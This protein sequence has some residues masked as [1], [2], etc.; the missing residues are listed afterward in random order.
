M[1][2]RVAIYCRLSEE[3]REKDGPD[4]QSIQNQRE[5]LRQY[6]ADRNWEVVAEWVDDD[7]AGAD[8]NRP[9]FR[10][11]LYEAERGA[12]VLSAWS[13]MPTPLCGTIKKLARSTD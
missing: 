3:D 4:S 10:Q 5:M 12:C 7:W 8:R 1:R 9:G 6:A 13:T 2:E 11:L